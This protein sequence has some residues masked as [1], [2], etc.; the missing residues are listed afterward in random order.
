[1]IQ[2]SENVDKDTNTD[3]PIQ[4]EFF[5]F[6]AAFDYITIVEGASADISLKSL[7]FIPLNSV[8]PPDKSIP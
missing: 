4:T 2:I 6:Y 7:W 5:Q 3:P 8:F 1:M